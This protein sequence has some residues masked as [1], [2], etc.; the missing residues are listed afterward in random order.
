[1]SQDCM[2]PES[3]PTSAFTAATALGLTPSW[4]RLCSDDRAGNH[5]A[6]IT[7]GAEYKS[8][9]TEAWAEN[10]EQ[11]LRDIVDREANGDR[12]ARIRLDMGSTMNQYLGVFREESGMREALGT[13]AQLKDRYVRVPVEDK[14]RTFNTDLV[15]ALELGFM[16]DC[17]ESIV[18]GGIDRKESRGAHSRQDYTERDDENWLK[19]VLVTKSE[20]GPQ[21]SYLPVVITQWQ[22]E[23][24]RY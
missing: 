3:V 8:F 17:A 11:R 18:V 10:E 7:R 2:P 23:E 1:M 12:V 15:F 16:L 24:R 13:I 21:V 9:N 20:E 5:A 14:G 22:P 19:H 6:E 4:T